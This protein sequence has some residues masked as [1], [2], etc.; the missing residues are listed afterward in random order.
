MLEMV[1][2][3]HSRG[4]VH[5]DLKPE[6][7]LLDSNQESANL[8]ATDF[9]LSCFYKGPDFLSDPC[10][11]PMYIAPEVIKGKYTH[12]ADIWSAGVVLYIL[13]SG[14]VPFYGRTD[15]EILRMTLRGHYN[16]EKEP[17]P[18]ISEDAKEC[19]RT[20]LTWDPTKRP[21][22]KEM[23]GHRWMREDGTATDKPLV[24]SV[25]DNLHQFN[26][27]NKFKKK[28]LQL[29]ACNMDEGDLRAVR[30]V[31]FSYER[32]PETRV[33]VF[34]PETFP[35]PFPQCVWRSGIRRGRSGRIGHNHPGGN[36]NCS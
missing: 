19:V 26:E 22:A 33:W 31:R 18:H 30:K 16:L 1:E 3:C 9:G 34:N 5:R 12:K 36:E 17:W 2:H 11:T 20:M 13:L 14:K 15:E 28:A 6:N 23:L 27:M 25:L 8:K 7:F 29:M 32:G 35:F 4:V 21:E 10:G 24:A